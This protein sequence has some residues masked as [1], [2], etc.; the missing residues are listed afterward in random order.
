MNAVIRNR[1]ISLFVENEILVNV[2]HL[3][4]HQK[5]DS[6][7]ISRFAIRNVLA[8][9]KNGER[10]QENFEKN[11]RKL[12]SSLPQ[13]GIL[14]Q[15]VIFESVERNKK[16]VLEVYQE[17]NRFYKP[18]ITIWLPYEREECYSDL[19][20]TFYQAKLKEQEDKRMNRDLKLIQSL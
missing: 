7:F 3:V 13:G 4:H 10:N 12:A 5:Y 20:E 2:S 11:V 15:E 1:F 9:I 17:S 8:E 19:A 14:R 18:L 16:F 6:F